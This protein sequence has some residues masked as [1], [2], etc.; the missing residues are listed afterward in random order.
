MS[1]AANKNDVLLSNKLEIDIL[2][3]FALSSQITTAIDFAGLKQNTNFILIGIGNKQSLEKLSNELKPL[4][5]P[6]FSKNN[7]TFIKKHSKI[8]KKYL[9][10]VYSKNPL[11]DILIEKAAILF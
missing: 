5:T 10:S 1:F 11:E 4:S 8:T 7:T 9:D 3:R 2:M 6:M